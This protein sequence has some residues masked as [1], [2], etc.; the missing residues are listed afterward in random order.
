MSIIWTIR[1]GMSMRTNKNEMGIRISGIMGF[2][3]KRM[4]NW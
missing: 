2:I 4:I 1:I 3:P